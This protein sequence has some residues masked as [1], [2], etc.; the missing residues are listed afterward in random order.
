[1]KTFCESPFS[2]KG[3]CS[4]LI[5]AIKKFMH[6][7]FIEFGPLYGTLLMPTDYR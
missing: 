2:E 5:E 7:E 4:Y 1:M 6:E 3:I